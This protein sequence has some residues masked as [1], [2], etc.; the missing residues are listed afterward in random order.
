[1]PSLAPSFLCPPRRQERVA[2]LT[3]HRYDNGVTLFVSDDRNAPMYS[4]RYSNT[5]S[6][7]ERKDQQ[8]GDDWSAVRCGGIVPDIVS[9][10]LAGLSAPVWH[11]H[12]PKFIFH[13]T[14]SPLAE[15]WA[16]ST[17]RYSKTHMLGLRSLRGAFIMEEWI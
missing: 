4:N 9:C 1:M 3:G 12:I 11:I 6:T 7:V 16:G 5:V 2:S 15:N 13:S 14:A 17:T 8:G 10:A